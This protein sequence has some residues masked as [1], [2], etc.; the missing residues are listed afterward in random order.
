MI[1]IGLAFNRDGWSRAVM[2]IMNQD[3]LSL[4][5]AIDRGQLSAAELM[6]ATLARINSTR[7]GDCCGLA[8]IQRTD[9][10]QSSSRI[11]SSARSRCAAGERNARWQC[12]G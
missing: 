8:D 11:V 12:V 4:S 10:E 9:A 3:A 6:Q 1:T 7:E 5:K 2:D